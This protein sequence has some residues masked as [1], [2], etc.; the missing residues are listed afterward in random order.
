MR[1]WMDAGG[2]GDRVE[3]M[4]MDSRYVVSQLC[5]PGRVTLTQ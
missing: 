2:V 1:G 5:A 4:V 3:A